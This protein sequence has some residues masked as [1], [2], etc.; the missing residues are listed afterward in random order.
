MRAS[1]IQK[2]PLPFVNNTSIYRDKM[3]AVISREKE[4]A[5][6]KPLKGESE[7]LM[8]YVEKSWQAIAP[9]WPLENLIAVNPLQ[10][11]ENLPIAFPCFSW[12]Y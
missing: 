4:Q 7:S 1:P 9:F 2:Q 11:L 6:K 5:V 8:S 12:P 10:G 3:T